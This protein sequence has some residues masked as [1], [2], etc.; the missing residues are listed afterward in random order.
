[1]T[2]SRSQM[3]SEVPQTLLVSSFEVA[4]GVTPTN[5]GYPTSPFHDIRRYGYVGDGNT[6]DAVAWTS[7]AAVMAKGANGYVPPG[8]TFVA[9]QVTFTAPSL[10][11]NVLWAY[12]VQLY[13][14]NTT[15]N[16]YGTGGG[17]AYAID[18]LRFSGGGNSDGTTVYGI[19]Y[20]QVDA[21]ATAGFNIYQGSSWV[22][23]DCAVLVSSTVAANGSFACVK[24]ITDYPSAIYGYWNKINNLDVR[25]TA[26]NVA[27]YAP[28]G[29]LTSGITNAI[30]IQ[31]CKFSGTSYSIGMYADAA[32]GLPN[33]ALITRNA[34]EG[35]VTAILVNGLSIGTTT[36]IVGLRITDNRAEACTSGFLTIQ[37]MTAAS[38]SYGSFGVPW[39]AGNFV[40][41]NAFPYYTQASN[42]VNFN[43]NSFDFNTVGSAAQT[44]MGG[45]HSNGPVTF[46]SVAST[47][48]Q[49]DAIIGQVQTNGGG[50]ALL[51]SA[52][53]LLAAMRYNGTTGV[54]Y[55]GINQVVGPRITGYGT[56]TGNVNQGS[57]AAGSITLP[58]LAAAV[59][60]LIIDL[61]THG[62]LGT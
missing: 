42:A 48:G 60:Q 12:G 39:L 59:A 31:D 6:N 41:S 10:C 14:N 13:T 44:G 49:Y 57:F 28:F 62:L 58:N 7:L 3:L 61:K 16:P 30:T 5:Y 54:Y 11:N 21:T 9:S 8:P 53:T 19:T 15:A 17:A 29:V 36:T 24:V 47:G 40:V 32:G 26:G 55:S 43:I 34:F 23:Q 4:A 18:G 35:A 45:F 50:F 1:M 33:A 25:Q 38:Y 27:T 37:G 51:N 56:P 2:L 22:L 52:G 20:N 46:Q